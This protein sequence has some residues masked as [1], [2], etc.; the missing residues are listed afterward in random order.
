ME[1]NFLSAQQEKKRKVQHESQ[2]AKERYVKYWK[3]KL[4]GIYTEQ[5]QT[6]IEVS[7][8]KEESKR[9]L[10]RLEKDEI[11]LM[12]EINKYHSQGV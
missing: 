7:K 3:D 2:A 11:K 8:Q 6:I 9:E 4:A 10:Q 5:A 1:R 12:E